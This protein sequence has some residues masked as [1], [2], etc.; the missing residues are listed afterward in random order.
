LVNDEYLDGLQGWQERYGND[1]S[2][3]DFLTW[4]RHYTSSSEISAAS[5]S[6]PEP[7]AL[8]LLGAMSCLV[9]I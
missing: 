7:T 4:E 9:L 5:Q 8:A 2:G 3:K 6:I 1:L